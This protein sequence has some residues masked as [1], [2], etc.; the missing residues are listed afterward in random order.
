MTHRRFLLHR[1]VDVSG[2]SGTGPVAEGVE[3]S[4]GTAT[5]RWLSDT[6]C[7]AV[8][9]NLAAVLA[10][11][12]HDGKTVVLWLDPEPVPRPDALRRAAASLGP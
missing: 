11:H 12:G 2:V 1:H 7:T 6:P 10:V 5:V 8:W 3:F 4:D 9:P